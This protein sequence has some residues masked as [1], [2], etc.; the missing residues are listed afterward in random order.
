MIPHL[1]TTTTAAEFQALL[2]EIGFWPEV[3]PEA[4]Y[5]DTV[6]PH[7]IPES[8]VRRFANYVYHGPDPVWPPE[9]E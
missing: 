3:I 2:A 9:M 7:G 8:W 6:L 1:T 5:P 4:T